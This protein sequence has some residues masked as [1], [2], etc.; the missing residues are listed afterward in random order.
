MTAAPVRI[1]R[2]LGATPEE[3]FDAWTDPRSLAV[4]MCPGSTRRATAEADARVGG[5]FRIVMQ[6]PDCDY[7]HTGEY[8]VVDRPRRLVFTWTSEAT[9]GR[10]TTVSVELEPRGPGE[11][12]LTLTHEG[13]A[14]EEAAGRHRSGWGDITAKL[15]KALAERR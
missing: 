6:G 2:V 5:R 12:V 8:L 15:A 14:D 7:A 10:P 1:V 13:L 3:V 4:W 9:K 11:T